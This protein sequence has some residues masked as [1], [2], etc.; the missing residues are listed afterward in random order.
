MES[1]FVNGVGYILGLLVVIVISGVFLKPITFIIKLLLNSVL[2]LL[3]IAVI[4]F[5]ASPAGIN[6]G[7]NP[8]T[9]IAVGVL[10][11]PG[12]ILILLAQ[13]FY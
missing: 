13:I 4:N 10:G 6:I 12:V 9:A 5:L 2:G 1:V 8:I 7:L 3:C 11:V